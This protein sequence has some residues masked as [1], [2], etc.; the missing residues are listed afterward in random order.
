MHPL[1]IAAGFDTFCEDPISSF[2]LGEEYYKDMSA[3]ISALN[4]PSL[5]VTEGG[6]TVTK[7][8][9]LLLNFMHGWQPK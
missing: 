9:T 4:V 2:K 5:V 6:Y 8:G 7:L 3:M 1:N